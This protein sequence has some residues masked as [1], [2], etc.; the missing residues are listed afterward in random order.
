VAVEQ[1]FSRGGNQFVPV[2]GIAHAGA[3]GISR[4]ELRIDDGPWEPARL[5]APLS[6]TT[7]VL[8]RYDWPF[9]E[10]EHTLTVRCLEGDG[11]PQIEDE[12]DTHP[13]GA[14]GLHS[15]DAEV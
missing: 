9:T 6:A 1:A 4:V 13:S 15:E 2:G 11:R 12:T 7:W 10:G 3:R 5:R 14:T 8:W